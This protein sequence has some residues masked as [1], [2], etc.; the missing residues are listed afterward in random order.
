MSIGAQFRSLRDV[1]ADAVR[2]QIVEGT[3]APGQRL[4]ERDLAEDFEVSRITLRE[5]L[6]QLAAEGLVTVVPRKGALVT[7]LTRQDVEDLFDVRLALEVLAART[8]ARRRTDED[9]T[10]LRGLLVDA[11]SAHAAGDDARVAMLNTA[12][13]L[14]V[15]RVAQ[16][17]MLLGMMSSVQGHLRRLFRLAREID[18][19]Q[20]HQD[21]Q[22]LLD[23]LAD[24]DADRAGRIAHDHIEETRQ[25]TV[26]L[27][28]G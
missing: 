27:L 20:L 16:N 28:P 13:H 19:T 18:P 6:A 21:H 9:L 3:F 10:R 15:V 8:A 2:E 25:P 11:G 4:V 24:G 23:A 14:E 1:V 12:F 22:A 17:P 7:S 26:R 5:A